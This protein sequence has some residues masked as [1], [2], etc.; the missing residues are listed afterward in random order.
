MIVYANPF[1]APMIFDS[2]VLM[3]MLCVYG[4][5]NLMLF[6]RIFQRTSD[7]DKK[8]RKI[9]F[10]LLKFN[11]ENFFFFEFEIIIRFPYIAD[12]SIA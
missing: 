2:V 6:F 7:V 10:K 4:K 3:V 11:K 1:F 5:S 9:E 12:H 8:E